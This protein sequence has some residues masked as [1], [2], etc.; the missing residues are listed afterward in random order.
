[1]SA[2]LHLSNS[3][4]TIW[5]VLRNPA[6]A[7][8]HK[9]W[10]KKSKSAFSTTVATGRPMIKPTE[11]QLL[12]DS[13]NSQSNSRW[14]SLAVSQGLSKRKDKRLGDAHSGQV[15]KSF[16]W[17]NSF[18]YE[19]LPFCPS[20]R[21]KGERRR[22]KKME[23]ELRYKKIYSNILEDLESTG[24]NRTHRS[25]MLLVSSARAH[26]DRPPWLATNLS[27]MPFWCRRRYA[28]NVVRWFK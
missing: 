22:G 20:P 16:T 21:L 12:A 18:P 6:T 9:D 1:M 10:I 7:T 24:L 17:L 3:N 15:W 14:L 25:C 11:K 28:W 13:F 27:S 5:H 26:P 2:T 4:H 23:K 19:A 8:S